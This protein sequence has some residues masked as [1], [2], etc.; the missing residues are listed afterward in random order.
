M[1]KQQI[2]ERIARLREYPRMKRRSL[3]AYADEDTSGLVDGLCVDLAMSV[4][5][6]IVH[7]IRELARSRGIVSLGVPAPSHGSAPTTGAGGGQ[8]DGDD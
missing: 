3:S 5:D 2:E 1:T 7:A 8:A 6:M 4:S